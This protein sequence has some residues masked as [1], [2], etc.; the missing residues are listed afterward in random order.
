MQVVSAHLR[1]KQIKCGTPIVIEARSVPQSF[2][3]PIMSHSNTTNPIMLH[4]NRSMPIRVLFLDHTAKLGGGEIALLN[5]VRNL[6]KRFIHTTVVLFE[7][8]PLVKQIRL[9]AE[10]HV[11]PLSDAVGAAAKDGLG[12][13]SLLQCNAA[14]LACV[15]SWKVARLVSRT[16]VHLIHTNSLKADI[17]G[18][19]AGWLARVPVIWHVRD[20]IEPEYLPAAVVR[21]FRWLSR[22]MPAYVIANS[23]ATLSSLRLKDGDTRERARVVHDGC[24]VGALKEAHLTRNRGMRIGLIGRISPWKGQHIFLQAAALLHPLYPAAKFE[25]IGAPLF[26]EREYEAHLHELNSTLQLGDAVEFAGFIDDVPARIAQ[27]DIVVH[28]STIGEPFGQVIIEAMAERKPVAA[29]NGGGVPEVVEDGITGLLVPMGDAPSMAQALSYLLDH[30]EAAAEM[31]NRG[32]ERVR[33]KFT[34]QRTARSVES[35]YRHVLQ[36]R[37]RDAQ[38]P[39]ISLGEQRDPPNEIENVG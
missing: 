28:A 21:I 36:T 32:W 5:L 1:E 8:G 12:W 35:V 10:T 2:T 24:N 25:I 27:L 6:D 17:I 16:G 14:L 31:G 30:P 26:S 39:A 15:H 20:R 13:K 4:T 33:A 37:S 3:I 23:Q 7:D 29:T 22:K 18:G 38:I 9:H 11:L 34:I 19:L